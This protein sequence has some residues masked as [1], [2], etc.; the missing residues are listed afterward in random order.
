VC[1]IV[2]SCTILIILLTPAFSPL[3]LTLIRLAMQYSV[4]VCAYVCVQDLAVYQGFNLCHQGLND[5][6]V[7]SRIRAA[8]LALSPD[9]AYTCPA[10]AARTH[11]A[12]AAAR[13]GA[14][15][16][17]GGAPSSSRTAVGF[18]SRYFSDHS[19]G[20]IFTET[21][22]FL[23]QH[24]DLDI[25]VYYI[26][27]NLEEG[28]GQGNAQGQG[29][30]Q[31]QHDDYVT[32]ALLAQLGP[33]RFTR[34]PPTLAALRR[35]LS[36]EGGGG[37]GAAPALDVLVFTDVGMDLLSFLAA[38]SRLAPY[39]VGRQTDRLTADVFLMFACHMMDTQDRIIVLM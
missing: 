12:A 30:G 38:S 1:S 17:A 21:I 25:Y 29:Q 3:L 34:V 20:R 23:H 6:R 18:V 2:S 39:Q 14:G 15:A 33:S 10:L 7:Q 26:D 24:A 28:Q 22:L 5:R 16:G 32:A 27:D 13:A 37:E 8:Y 11:A 9:I 36:P 35:A 4:Y 19:I 31:G